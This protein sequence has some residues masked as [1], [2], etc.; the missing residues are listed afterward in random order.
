MTRAMAKDPLERFVSIGAFL[1]ALE[2]DP[3]TAVGARM[4]SIAVLPFVNS[5]PDPENEYLS[6]GITDEL[7]DALS[8]VKGLRVASRTSVANVCLVMCGL[9]CRTPAAASTRLH[10]S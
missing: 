2:D 1:T 4:R 9:R 5:S 8:K 7:I 10:H 3:A 6:D